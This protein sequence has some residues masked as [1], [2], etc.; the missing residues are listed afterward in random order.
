MNLRERPQED[1]LSEQIAVEE[2]R[3]EAERFARVALESERALHRELRDGTLRH[4][5][6]TDARHDGIICRTRIRRPPVTGAGD[7]SGD[8]WV[9]A[10]RRRVEGSGRRGSDGG[11][12]YLTSYVLRLKGDRA[13]PFPA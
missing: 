1:V 3:A 8:G 7:G 13:D 11:G 12:V 6:L 2:N 9:M 10:G 5:Q 4:E